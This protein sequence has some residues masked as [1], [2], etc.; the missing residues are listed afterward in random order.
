MTQ[1]LPAS[2]LPLAEAALE[3]SNGSVC[4][5]QLGDFVRSNQGPVRSSHALTM[6][7]M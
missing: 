2:A 6:Q 7:M 1:L 3:H 4:D 5:V